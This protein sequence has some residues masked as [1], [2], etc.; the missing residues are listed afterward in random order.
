ML[1]FNTKGTPSIQN[2]NLG[3]K[4]ELITTSKTLVAQSE[5][6]LTIKNKTLELDFGNY[7]VPKL[8]YINDKIYV[9][10]TDLQTQKV[11]LYDSNAVL[12]KH[13]PVYGNSA[14]ILDNIDNDRN[15][16]FITKGEN[17]AIIIYQIN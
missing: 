1:S 4:H 7:D 12:Q 3:Q 11:Y 5:N 9:S 15:L 10:I 16:E 13:I 17:N 8:F 6:K 2:L 14:I